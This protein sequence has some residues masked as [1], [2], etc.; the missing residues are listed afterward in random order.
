MAA[1][2][3]RMWCLAV[4]VGSIALSACAPTSP[5]ALHAPEQPAAST[6][7]THATFIGDSL[8]LGK[9]ATTDDLAYHGVLLSLIHKHDPASAA[10]ST[11][12]IVWGFRTA[13][14]MNRLL[15]NMPYNQD[16]IVLEMGINDYVFGMSGWQREY[17][18][19]M[20][21][22]GHASPHATFLC[23]SLWQPLG[24]NKFGETIDQFNA[25][26]QKMCVLPGHRTVFAYITD[27]YPNPAYH[28][29]VGIISRFG[30]PTDYFHPNDAGHQAIALRLFAALY[31]GVTP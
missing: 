20:T 31:P 9:Y 10:G 13:D 1:I 18:A 15:Q 24:H 26:V 28:G 6:H 17:T 27:M 11:K 21:M 5:A 16:L 25:L 12:T 29:P 23:V 2:A 22:L 4:L 30:D 7:F 3:R 8:T 19:M 14:L